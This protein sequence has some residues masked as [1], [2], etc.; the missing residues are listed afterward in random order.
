MR[1][2][3]R[4]RGWWLVNVEPVVFAS[5]PPAV[6]E[7]HW[8]SLLAPGLRHLVK[9][10][11]ADLMRKETRVSPEDIGA[12]RAV[13][14]KYEREFRS[15]AVYHEQQKASHKPRSIRPLEQRT[16]DVA[17]AMAVLVVCAEG[18]WF[19]GRLIV[20]P[21]TGGPAGEKP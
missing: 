1:I 11:A 14:E 21:I 5:T 4:L 19:D 16:R 15:L 10:E 13:V 8:R 3:E 6:I 7:E 2:I 20:R 17:K 12:A 9:V 18:A